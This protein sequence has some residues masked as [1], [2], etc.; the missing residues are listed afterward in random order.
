MTFEKNPHPHKPR[1][2][3]PRRSARLRSLAGLKPGL[4]RDDPQHR[5]DP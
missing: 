4:Y 1:M 2:E 5:I 3:H